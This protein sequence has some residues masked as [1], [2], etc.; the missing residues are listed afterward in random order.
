MNELEC[1]L[2]GTDICSCDWHT[3]FHICPTCLLQNTYFQRWYAPPIFVPDE[4]AIEQGYVDR[5]ILFKGK[6][7]GWLHEDAS[8]EPIRLG[9][10]EASWDIQRRISIAEGT[11]M[12][13][14]HDKFESEFDRTV[15]EMREQLLRGMQPDLV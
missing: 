3:R 12:P 6:E 2:C 7:L 1:V 5:G 8:F 4:F 15:R 9:D 11:P 10:E 14:Q 13:V